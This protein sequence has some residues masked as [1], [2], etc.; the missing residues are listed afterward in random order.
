MIIKFMT[1]IMRS[2]ISNILAP[3]GIKDI[4]VD[5]ALR[6][7]GNLRAIGGDGAWHLTE[8]TKRNR[9][10]LEAFVTDNPKSKDL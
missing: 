9:L 8:I 2:R 5:N 6:S 3:S 10:I 7:L 4:A 1:L